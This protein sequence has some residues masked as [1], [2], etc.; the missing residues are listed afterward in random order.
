MARKATPKPKAE[1]PLSNTVE[2]LW[3][4]AYTGVPE[5]KKL[6][7]GDIATLPP[8]AVEMLVAKGACRRV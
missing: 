1:K 2:C 6:F 4:K 7:K 5:R 3:D 8:E